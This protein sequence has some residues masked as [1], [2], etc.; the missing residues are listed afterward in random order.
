MIQILPQET[1]WADAGRAAGL[2]V[3][4]GYTEGID[5]RALQKSVMA[6]GPN[7]SPRQL[8]DAVTNTRTYDN[9]AKENFFKTAMGVEEFEQIKKNQKRTADLEQ[10][11]INIASAKEKREQESLNS[12]R[13][14]VQSIVS[15]IPGLT[16]EQQQSLGNSLDLRGATDL[17]KE[18]FKPAKGEKLGVFDRKVTD[19]G[20][21]EYVKLSQKIPRYEQNLKDLD[22]AQKISDEIGISDF[23]LGQIGQSGKGKLL[24]GIT[25]PQ[26]EPIL[27][28]LAPSGQIAAVKLLTAQK[29]YE[30]KASDTKWIRDAKIQALKQF[31]ESSKQIAEDRAAAL[32]EYKGLMPPEVENAINAKAAK[33][34][35]QIDTYDLVNPP[36]DPSEIP[37]QFTSNAD[38]YIDKIIT[39][40]QTK[41]RYKFDGTKWVTVQ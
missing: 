11:R 12:E 33:I 36:A 10:A 32:W 4:Q 37:V 5:E 6:L 28:I 25:F 15:T 8:L 16:P 34:E 30:V 23:A 2:G 26:L 17:V 27:H 22:E 3:V 18:A 38:N 14:K 41:K 39:N 20:A 7:P 21:E 9:K 40:P 31:N 29:K 35:R 13:G 1:G 19:K 24:E